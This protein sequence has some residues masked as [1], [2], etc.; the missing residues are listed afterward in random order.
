M[1]QRRQPLTVAEMQ[2]APLPGGPHY[3][4][5]P[6]NTTYERVATTHPRHWDVID[7][8]GQA[9]APQ[10][11]MMGPAA[12]DIMVA[13]SGKNLKSREQPPVTDI[14]QQAQNAPQPSSLPTNPAPFTGSAV[15]RQVPYNMRHS[16]GHNAYGPIMRS[17][18]QQ[19]TQATHRQP[20]PALPCRQTSRYKVSF[21]TKMQEFGTNESA[22]S[23]VHRVHHV[24]HVRQESLMH[25]WDP[26]DAQGPRPHGVFRPPQLASGSLPGDNR[27]PRTQAAT[28][29]IPEESTTPESPHGAERD[30]I[31]PA[32]ARQPVQLPP[33][34]EHLKDVWNG[35]DSAARSKPTGPGQGCI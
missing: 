24:R 11:G 32:T 19:N 28:G 15:E 12:H 8:W 9:P 3:I 25:V 13:S 30:G 4:S 27:A 21:Q 5:R 6:G 23:Q 20:Q 1:G 31:I 35:L 33:L 14:F 22:K 29:R 26:T 16:T 7:G 17:A 34:K 18:Q 10:G 2:N